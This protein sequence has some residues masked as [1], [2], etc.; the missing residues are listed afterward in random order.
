MRYR[1]KH[2]SEPKNTI[3]RY[4]QNVVMVNIVRKYKRKEN[5]KI[6]TWKF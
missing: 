6:I 3:S 1:K 2:V 4:W 5:M